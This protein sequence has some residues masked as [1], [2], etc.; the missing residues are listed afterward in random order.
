MT[1]HFKTYRF[2]TE[3]HIQTSGKWIGVMMQG[4]ETEGISDYRIE[5]FGPF[6]DMGLGKP[7]HQNFL[8]QVTSPAST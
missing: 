2:T 6:A 8:T 5:M 3:V 4:S 1:L 7:T